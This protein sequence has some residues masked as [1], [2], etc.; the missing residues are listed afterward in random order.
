[1]HH[2]AGSSTLETQD[3]WPCCS[4]VWFCVCD[5][6]TSGLWGLVGMTESMFVYSLNDG[7]IAHPI[8]NLLKSCSLQFFI[9]VPKI[10]HEPQDSREKGSLAY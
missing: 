5:V 9:S 4:K 7:Y 6:I 1:M 2:L 3:L 10:N 8:I